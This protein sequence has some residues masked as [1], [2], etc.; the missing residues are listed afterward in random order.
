MKLKCRCASSLKKHRRSL[1]A[2]RMAMIIKRLLWV[3]VVLAATIG[4]LI[5]ITDRIKYLVSRPTATTISATRHHTLTFPAVTVCNLNSFRVLGVLEEL[6]LTDLIQIAAPLVSGDEID[7]ETCNQVLQSASTSSTDILSGITFE[8][9]AVQSRQPVEDFIQGCFFAG[10]SCGNVTEVFEPVFTNL[11][12]CYTFNSGRVRPLFQSSGTGQRQGLQLLLNVNQ[13]SNTT[14]ILNLGLIIAINAQSEHPVPANLG[15]GV[16]AG[17]NAFI[18][19]EQRNTQDETKRNCTC[20]SENDY[21]PT[22]NFLPG[23]SYS[24]STCLVDCMHSRI[25]DDCE[26]IVARSF[27]SPGIAR[28]SQL[29]DCTLEKICCIVDVLPFLQNNCNCRSA[30]SFTQYETSTSYSSLPAEELRALAASFGL[31]STLFPN[32][33]LMVS[34]Y[35]ETLN[36]E[37]QTTSSVYSFIALLS[38]IGGQV[39]LFLGLSVISVLQFGDWIIKIMRSRNLGTDLKR[40]KDKCLSCCHKYSVTHDKDLIS[41]SAMSEV[42]TADKPVELISVSATSEISTADKPV[43]THT[44]NV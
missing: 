39:G 7:S 44:A 30:C 5:T 21:E 28:Y 35:F 16:P 40:M 10:K 24:E 37:T 18:S 29:P 31:E 13:Q 9:L 12:I 11:G 23:A 14:T 43:D 34:V 33:F 15:I 32:D 36:V 26:C 20:S 8:E 22:F 41:V 3:G 4:C 17:R 42:S 2:R 6:N 25:A 27:Y 1:T 38:D 19:M